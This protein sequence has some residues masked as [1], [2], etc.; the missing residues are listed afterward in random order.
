MGKTG[1]VVF[2]VLLALSS[3]S[4]AAPYNH[5]GTWVEI[6]YWS[7]SGD[8]KAVCVIDFGGGDSYAFGYLWTGAATAWDMVQAMDAPG[9]LGMEYTMWNFGT[10]EDPVWA[11][12]IDSFTYDTHTAISDWETSFLGYWGSQDGVSWTPHMVGVAGRSLADGCWDGWSLEDPTI[13]YDPLNAPVT[14]VPEP[15]TIGLMGMGLLCLLRRG[16]RRAAGS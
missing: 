16:R 8:S 5:G 4:L 12:A 10:A 15:A 2:L 7:G 9:G 6:E 1:F 13:S 3:V 14:P 11:P